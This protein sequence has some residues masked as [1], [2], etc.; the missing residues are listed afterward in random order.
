MKYW[1]VLNMIKSFFKNRLH[2][3][4]DKNSDITT[5]EIEKSNKILFS[6]FSRYGDGIISF[7]VIN[8][9]IA[10]YPNKHYFILTSKQQL[11][12]AQ[13]IITQK[14]VKFVK[15]NK[16]NLLQLYST[17]RLLKKEEIDLGF[18]P[19]G[20]GDDS[21]FFITYCKKFSYYKKLDLYTKTYN[22]YDR[23]REYLSLDIVENKTLNEPILENIKK[24]IIAP[25]SSD[26]TKN[27]NEVSLGM[28]IQ[29]LNTTFEKPQITVA[30]PKEEKDISVNCEKFIFSKSTK[31]SS[32]YLDQLLSSDLF[33]GV[34]SGP[35]HLAL[36]LNIDSIAVFGPTAPYTILDHNQTVKVIRDKKLEEIF[37]FVK[38]CRNPICINRLFDENIQDYRYPAEKQVILEEDTCPIEQ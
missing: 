6:I 36:A 17:I 8:E 5:L 2:K 35:L 18:N 33:I 9:F 32:I 21:E 23:V 31:A 13:K 34:D 16:R 20:H 12:Y 30:L 11:P 1:R 3:Y 38:N 10:K 7:K 27:I 4:N 25:I 29:Q 14:N 28:L 22:L 15:V 26:V 37:C 24:I 19:W